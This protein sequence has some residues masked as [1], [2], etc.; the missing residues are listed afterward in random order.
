MQYRDLRDFIA[1]LESRGELKHLPDSLP[2]SGG[3]L[4]PDLPPDDPR[5]EIELHDEQVIPERLFPGAAVRV[6][7]TD[8]LP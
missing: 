1:Q 7:L 5:D 3:E 6:A 8:D 4:H 2:I